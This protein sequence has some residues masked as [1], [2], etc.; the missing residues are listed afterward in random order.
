MK[1]LFIC[2]GNMYRSQM[3]AALYNKM[4]GTSDAFSVGTYPGA[5]EEPEGQLLENLPAQG[6]L[7]SHFFDLMEKNGM[8]VKG[9]KTTRLLP[10]MLDEYDHVVSMAEDPYIPNFLKDNEKVI[11]WSVKNP[12]FVTKEVAED[13]YNQLVGLV[14][15][16]VSIIN[17]EESRV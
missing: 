17:P 8:N 14:T 10:K 7:S 3:A 11:R 13:T 2:K 6:L 16:L 1:V 9:N 15:G 5:P 4:T 12:T